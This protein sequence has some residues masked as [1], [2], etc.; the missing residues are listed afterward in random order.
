MTE[1]SILRFPISGK[2]NEY[3]LLEASSNGSRPLDLKLIGSEST[4]VFI[5]KL[6]HKRIGDYKASSG[7]CSHEEWEKILTSALIDQQP[8]PDVE[9]RADV[10]SDGTSVS[11]SFRKNIQGITQR[12]GSIKLEEDE[13]TEISPFDWCVSAI[14]TRERVGEDLAAATAKI[15]NLEDSLKELRE[16]LDDLIKTKEEDETQL[17][18]KF[19]DL[20]NEKKVKIRQQQRLLASATVDPE[21]LA[22]VGGTPGTQKHVAEASRASKRKVKDE[23]ESSGDDSFEKMDV[24]EDSDDGSAQPGAEENGDTTADETASG[25][26][27]DS[28]PAPPPVK[29]QKNQ[30][31]MQEQDSPESSSEQETSKAKISKP[32]PRRTL[33]LN[34]KPPAPAPQP[35]DDDETESDD[36][37]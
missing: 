20:L 24:V 13:K 23:P 28:E 33:P 12:L 11:L 29:S 10:Q 35:V 14:G 27:T 37:L 17:L 9:I 18:E 5:T 36:E 21:K 1:A 4:A 16:Q 26:D 6:R 25:T 34:K 3:F 19:R 7:P 30:A 32:P 8:V 22:K 15:R 31:A 2:E